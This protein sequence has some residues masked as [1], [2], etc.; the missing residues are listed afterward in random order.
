MKFFTNE[1]PEIIQ[2]GGNATLGKG[3]VRIIKYSEGGKQ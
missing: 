1:I 2:I 3:I